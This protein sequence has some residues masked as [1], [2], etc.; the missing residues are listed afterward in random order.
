MTGPP[1]SHW[2]ERMRDDYEERAAIREFDGGESRRRAEWAAYH[3][4]AGRKG[5]GE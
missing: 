5:T 2:P 1:V 3:E 4:V